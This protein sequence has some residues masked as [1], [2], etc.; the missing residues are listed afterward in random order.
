MRSR[1]CAMRALQPV[2]GGMRTVQSLRGMQSMRGS[3]PVQSLWALR[4]V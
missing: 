1:L 2:C 4:T 3:K